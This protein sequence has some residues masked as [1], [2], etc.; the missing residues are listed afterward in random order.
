MKDEEFR[1]LCLLARLD[2]EDESLKNLKKD[3]DRILEYVQ[4]IG[5]LDTASVSDEYAAEDTRSVVRA[6]VPKPALDPAK[7]AAIAPDWESGH[8]VVPGVIESEG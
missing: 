1:E 4:H 2:P 7:I 6:D 8:F 3:F 5:N